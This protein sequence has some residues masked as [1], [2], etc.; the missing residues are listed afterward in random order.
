MNPSQAGRARLRS[1]LKKLTDDPTA[2]ICV[3]LVTSCG[4]TWVS[5]QNGS[6]DVTTLRKLFTEGNSFSKLLIALGL[7][8]LSGHRAMQWV[9]AVILFVTAIPGAVQFSRDV[10]VVIDTYITSTW[11]WNLI[12]TALFRWV[13]LIAPFTILVWRW[14]RSRSWF[15]S[16]SRPN[17]A[18]P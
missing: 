11:Y 3:G 15:R 18:T 2:T 12:L 5:R 1:I 17:G 6:F 14:L 16:Q 9:A 10:N 4:M 8:T 7:A 13:I